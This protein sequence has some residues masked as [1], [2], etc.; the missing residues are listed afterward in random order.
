MA[1]LIVCL[2]VG[3]FAAGFWFGGDSGPGPAPEGMVW[4]PEGEFW[5]GSD[6]FPDARP[7]HRV[8]VDGFWMDQTEVTNEQFARFVEA[9]GYQTIAER[10]PDPKDFPNLDLAK[11]GTKTFVPFSL[12][13]VAPKTCPPEL[14]GSCDRCWKPTAGACWKHPEGPGS[15]IEGREKH[16]VVHIAWY[17][18]VEYAKWA[19]KRLP[20]EA[21]WERAARGGLEGKP[22]YWGDELNPGGKWMANIWQGDFPCENTVA[23]GY[24]GTA[25]V[26]S[27]PPNAYGLYDMAGN[28]WEWC[29]D[30]YLPY[31]DVGPS[32]ILRNP[33]GPSYSLDTHGR[34]EL[35]R[36]QRG[37]SFLC[38]DSYCAR[39]RAGGRME[40]EPKTGLAHT[41]FRCVRSR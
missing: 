2:V 16:P 25:P 12:V 4:I 11:L 28:A 37:G 27:F 3:G 19:D 18:A 35:K 15:T 26:A 40:G 20:T 23:D 24:S 17:D 6:E 9:T 34:A 41:G 1:G 22:F 30:W 5:M 29:S 39:Y 10:Q 14:R 21:E 13:F 7:V 36:V 38:S 8:Y 32:G 31:F 33:E